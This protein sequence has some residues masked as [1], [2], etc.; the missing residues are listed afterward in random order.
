MKSGI[1]I[2]ETNQNRSPN[3]AFTLSA[4]VTGLGQIYNGDLIRGLIFSIL[5]I[6]VTLVPVIAIILRPDSDIIYHFFIAVLFHLI[7]W[8]SSSMEAMYSARR[9]YSFTFKR[10]NNIYFYLAYGIIYS[11]LLVSIV[12]LCS[13][14]FSIDRIST[15]DM[16]PTFFN[17]EIILINNYLNREM[18][19]GDV[20]V[21]SNEERNWI[22]RIIAKE[23]ET[24]RFEDS[25]FYINDSG[26]QLGILNNQDIEK[27]KI[28]N[29]ADLFYEENGNRKY[30]VRVSISK[31]DDSQGNSKKPARKSSRPRLINSN[32]YLLSFDNRNKEN[33]YVVIKSNRVNGKVEGILI[34]SN[35]SRIL[36]RPF[37]FD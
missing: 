34:G 14:F 6:M 35:L 15:D 11:T 30:P 8:I 31:K 26:L 27:L 21:Y 23:G 37:L 17:G 4:F 13:I 20:I 28:V 36:L 3:M 29:S 19:I 16:D 9:I 18:K 10:F 2:S 24:Y 22:S 33:P 25:L 12:F 5:K 1:I 7:I 32:S